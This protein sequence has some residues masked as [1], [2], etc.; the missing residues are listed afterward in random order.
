[1]VLKELGKL[2][3]EQQ[4]KEILMVYNYLLQNNEIKNKFIAVDIIAIIKNTTKSNN[5]FFFE[6][7]NKI[8]LKI[9]LFQ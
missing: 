3:K 9:K 1:M 5:F 7:F 6:K 4:K 8:K 2:L